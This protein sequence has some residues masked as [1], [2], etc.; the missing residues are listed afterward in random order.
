MKRVGYAA[1][2]GMDSA[3]EGMPLRF[4]CRFKRVGQ[5]GPL[6][7]L[8]ACTKEEL[9]GYTPLDTVDTYIAPSFAKDSI[10]DDEYPPYNKPGAVTHWL[11]VSQLPLPQ[12]AAHSDPPD[13]H[14]AAWSG[15]SPCI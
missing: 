9:D 14:V 12:G 3:V 2:K 1:P 7:R 13:M 11:R 15:W 4:P 5:E 10:H 8:M 6:T